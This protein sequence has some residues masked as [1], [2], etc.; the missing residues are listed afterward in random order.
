MKSL[1]VTGTAVVDLSAKLADL[2]DMLFGVQLGGGTD[3]NRALTYCQ[4]LIRRPRDTI[5]ILMSDPC[6]G[7]SQAETLRS[8]A[9]VVAAG[10]KV[11]AMP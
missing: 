1:V 6:E 4:S 7:G 3:I 2:V 10:A 5:C 11:R 9:S 8:R